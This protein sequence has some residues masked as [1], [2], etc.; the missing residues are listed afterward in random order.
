MRLRLERSALKRLDGGA[1]NVND[2]DAVVAELTSMLQ[3][4][5]EEECVDKEGAASGGECRSTAWRRAMG[6]SVWRQGAGSTRLSSTGRKGGGGSSERV[7]GRS[8]IQLV[9]ESSVSEKYMRST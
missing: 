2:G 4:R 8:G 3:E 1:L 6:S 7:S 5:E 9:S